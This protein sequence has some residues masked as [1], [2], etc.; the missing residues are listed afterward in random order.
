MGIGQH[1]DCVLHVRLAI[2]RLRVN[3]AFLSR[4]ACSLVMISYISVNLN[5]D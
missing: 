5:T 1:A 3:T 2:A 4:V